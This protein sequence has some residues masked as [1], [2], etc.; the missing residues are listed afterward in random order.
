MGNPNTSAEKTESA[1]PRRR[2]KERDKGNISKSPDMNSAILLTAGVAMLALM[3]KFDIGS[4]QTM[5]YDTFTH[6]KPNDISTDDILLIILPYVQV[7]TRIVLPFILAL[8]IIGVLAIRLQIGKVFCPD[9]MKFDMANI[10]PEKW[11]KNA[12]NMLNPFEPRNMV[13]FLKSLIK[14]VIVFVCGYSA[15]SGRIDEIYGLM[16]ADITT[17]FVVVGSVLTQM[18][19]NICLAMLVI[20]F[21]DKKYQDYEYEKSIKMT[22]QE[23]KDDFKDAEGDPKVKSKIRGV[24]IKMLRQKMM[25][26]IP[27]ADVVVTNP[28][29]YA[30]ALKYDKLKSSAPIVLAKGVDYLAFKIREVALE[31][32]IPIVENPP[33]ARTLYKLVPINGIIP[34]DMF[35]A[36]A[37]VLAYV[38]N[39]NKKN[40]RK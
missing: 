39:L 25:A 19:I 1:T 23:V 13:E 12:Q 2:Q 6:L 27:N 8:M 10:S 28:T 34:S 15:V 40:G 22:K 33:L 17:G 16:G 18:V 32:K 37:E 36:V 7:L 4:I 26:E 9:K 35:V 5:L 29:H 30:V 20:G 21:I 38:Y 24:Q 31:N 14:L 3:S 11:V